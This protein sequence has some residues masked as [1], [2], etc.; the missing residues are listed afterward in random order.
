MRG[1]KKKE[2]ERGMVTGNARKG[3]SDRGIRGMNAMDSEKE[4]SY[5]TL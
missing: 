3:D 1:R 5:R 2:L 4:S